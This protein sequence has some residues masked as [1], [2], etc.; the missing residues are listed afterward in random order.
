MRVSL[1]LPSVTWLPLATALARAS[2]D[3]QVLISEPVTHDQVRVEPIPSL[4][5]D[6]LLRH[7]ALKLPLNLDRH[8]SRFRPDVI[9]VM[10]EPSYLYTF[11]A[12]R[13]ADRLDYSPVFSCRAAQNIK[14][15]WPFPF[16]AIE[17]HL[18]KKV[19]FICAVSDD[20]H[21]VLR[22]KGY[23]GPI[24]KLPNGYDPA[25]FS[26]KQSKNRT[27]D[28]IHF[29]FVGNFLDRKGLREIMKAF[30]SIVTA[31]WEITFVGSGPLESELRRWATTIEGG[32][33]VN[34]VG[35]VPHDQLA[36][37]YKAFDVLLLVSKETNGKDYGPRVTPYRVSWKEQFGRVIV[38]AM[39]C[40]TPTLGSTSGSIPDVIGE[41]GWVVKEGDVDE[42][43]QMLRRII[44][45]PRCI[46]EKSKVAVERAKQYTWDFV[47]NTLVYCW[48]DVKRY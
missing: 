45:S 46:L 29:G 34:V 35:R 4:R 10:G 5:I 23:K 48:R 14:Q 37:F 12:S 21:D 31:P 6:R 47:A 27:N 28:P 15:D 39:A 9:H 30:S 40:G 33:R 32:H 8:I 17:Q 41:S 36:S 1:C 26:T 2:C 38:E 19:N 7:D 25:L 22:E 11:K 42:L 43:A 24:V 13:S 16:N 20:A 18:Y 44:A 3:V